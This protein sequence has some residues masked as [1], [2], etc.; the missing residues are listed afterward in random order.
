LG[1]ETPVRAGL[2]ARV[3]AFFGGRQ[4]PYFTKISESFLKTKA[5]SAKAESR[6]GPGGRLMVGELM[7]ERRETRNIEH[8]TSNAEHR[9]LNSE[10]SSAEPMEGRP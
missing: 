2:A 4:I 10:P 7:V 3:L 6:N 8:P 1:E 9:N 5:E